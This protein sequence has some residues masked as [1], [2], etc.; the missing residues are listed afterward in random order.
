[1]KIIYKCIPFAL[2]SAALAITVKGSFDASME[3]EI[4]LFTL[5]AITPYIINGTMTFFLLRHEMIISTTLSS[6]AQLV[7]SVL[8]YL[9]TSSSSTG[10]LIF[11][12]GPPFFLVIGFSFPLVAYL[13]ELNKK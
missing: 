10:A 9:D 5:W 2:L 3:V 6:L 13:I 4:D 8:F 11:L 7:L 12:F 1:M